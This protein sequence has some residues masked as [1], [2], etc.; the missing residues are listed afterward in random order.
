MSNIKSRHVDDEATK[1]TKRY[2]NEYE[3]I[4]KLMQ[5]T[6]LQR[7]KQIVRDVKTIVEYIV[8]DFK[9]AVNND[10]KNRITFILSKLKNVELKQKDERLI[11]NVSKIVLFENEYVL[12][13]SICST[14]LSDKK[15]TASFKKPLMNVFNTLTPPSRTARSILSKFVQSV[16]HFF[17]LSSQS[18][19]KIIEK[20]AEEVLHEEL[21]S[22]FAKEKILSSRKTVADDHS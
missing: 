13:L 17:N 15:T 11:E 10:Y 14:S 7:K 1:L 20:Q 6:V 3:K 16:I 22:P 5:Q 21:K 4:V 19:L 2:S 9:N 12:N 18:I 8:F